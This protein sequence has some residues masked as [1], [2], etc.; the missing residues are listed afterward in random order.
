MVPLQVA[1][2]VNRRV[3]WFLIAFISYLS[4]YILLDL[5]TAYCTSRTTSVKGVEIGVDLRYSQNGQNYVFIL[6]SDSVNSHTI[7]VSL[8]GCGLLVGQN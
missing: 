6:N 7:L 8:S 5:S 3:F 2:V 4:R 1:C